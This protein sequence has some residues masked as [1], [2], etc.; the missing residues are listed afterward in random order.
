MRSDGIHARKLVKAGLAR[1]L[2][3]TGTDALLGAIAEPP[4]TPVVLG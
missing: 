3:C 4:R 1:A 2:F